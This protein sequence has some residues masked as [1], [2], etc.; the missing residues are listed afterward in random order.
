LFIRGSDQRIKILPPQPQS[1][2]PDEQTTLC[3]N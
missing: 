2:A 3:K 1:R